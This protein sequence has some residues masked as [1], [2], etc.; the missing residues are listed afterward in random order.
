MGWGGC[1]AIEEAF[2]ILRKEGRSELVIFGYVTNYHKRG[3]LKQDTFII[4]SFPWVRN[5]GMVLYF[6]VSLETT[7]GCWAGL[8]SH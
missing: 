8:G 6:R 1:E 4:P 7:V 5:L 2:M 3:N